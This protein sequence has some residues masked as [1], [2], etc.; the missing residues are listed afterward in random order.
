MRE[1]HKWLELERFDECQCTK[2]KTKLQITSFL[3]KMLQNF[4]GR[5]VFKERRGV[6]TEAT[7]QEYI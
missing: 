5:T 4:R 3:N 2:D 1:A 6:T 7:L